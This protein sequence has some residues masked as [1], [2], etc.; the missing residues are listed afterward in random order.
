MKTNGGSIHNG[1]KVNSS[2]TR[3]HNE[4]LIEA[5]VNSLQMIFQVYRQQIYELYIMMQWY[6]VFAGIAKEHH[7]VLTLHLANCY[8]SFS[9]S[10]FVKV[11]VTL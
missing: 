7:N 3:K 11:Y 5:F 8:H 10:L 1:K 6:T 9:L 4:L 2:R